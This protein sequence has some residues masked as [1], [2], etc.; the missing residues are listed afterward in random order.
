MW[1][2]SFI[3]T[4]LL[5]FLACTSYSSVG[6]HGSQTTQAN[7]KPYFYWVP[8]VSRDCIDFS[9]LHSVIGP[10]NLQLSLE[11]SDEKLKPIKTLVIIHS[12]YFIILC[13][14]IRKFCVL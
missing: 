3:S 13:T 12:R 14:L 1:G 6:S 5:R 9:L 11:K 4:L 10:E 7:D 2:D 8:K